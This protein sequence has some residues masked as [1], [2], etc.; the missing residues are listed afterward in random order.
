V[1]SLLHLPNKKTDEIEPAL[2]TLHRLAQ[3]VTKVTHRVPAIA[4]LHFHWHRAAETPVV[5]P[6]QKEQRALQDPDESLGRERHDLPRPG[7]C[8]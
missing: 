2:R 3:T 4:Q 1:P 8:N 6:I 5:V 7:R